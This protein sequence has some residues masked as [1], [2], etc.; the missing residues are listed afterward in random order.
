MAE[1]GPAAPSAN[2][3]PFKEAIEFLRKKVNLPSRTWTDLWQGQHARAFV[4]AGAVKGQLVADF[5][6]AVVRAIGEGLTIADFRKDFDKIVADHVW[7]YKGGRN[8][9][10]AVI[11]NTNMRTAYAAGKWEQAQR[12]KD[13]RPYLRYVAVQDERTRPEHLEWHG[14][15]LSVDDPWWETHY[16]PNGWN[17]RCTV[18]Q[19][20]AADAE[21]L[22][23]EISDEAPPVDMETRSVNTPDG[24]VAVKVPKGIDTGFGYNVGLAAHGRGIGNARLDAHGDTFKPLEAPGVKSPGSPS[25]RRPSAPGP[26]S[27]IAPKARMGET[28]RNES[29]LRAALRQAL[30]GD[31]RILVDP[32]GERVAVNQ[33]IVDH[34]LAKPTRRDGRERFFPFIPELIEDPS[35]IWVGF[36]RN[37]RTGRVAIRRRY[38]KLLAIDKDRTLG[39]VADSDGGYWS[40]LTFF[41][42]RAEAFE[43]LRVGLR[44]HRKR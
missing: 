44:V 20:S 21:R 37:E 38:V 8:W 7:S 28:R 42:G 35:E 31:E 16:P 12:L 4:V 5:H 43:N 22:G 17:C 24:P 36:A 19:L 6:E 23:Y 1:Q 39:L 26:L 2:P 10:S 18:Q 13:R 40:G 41:S 34:M 14:K 15:V 9:R 33:A 27:A 11:F 32:A 30:G 3:V 25:A 29:G